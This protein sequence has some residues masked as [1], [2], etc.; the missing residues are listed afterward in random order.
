[1]VSYKLIMNKSL[2]N[3]P[4]RAVRN[5]FST[6]RH[7]PKAS[8]PFKL[9]MECSSICNLRC[10]MCPLSVGLKRKQGVLKFENFKYVF[11][12]VNPAYLNLTG[13]GE[14]FMNPDLFKIVKYAKQRNTMVKLDSNGTLLNKENIDKILDSKIDILST[15]IDGTDKKS[16]EKIRVG[17]NFDLI[18]KNIKALT[19]ERNRRK[20]KTEVHM[21]FILQEDN[22]KNLPNFIRLA[23]ELGVDYLAG[24]FVVTLGKNDNKKNKIFK[25]KKEDIDKAIKETEELIKKTKVEVSIIPLLEYLRND[26]DKEFYNKDTPCFMPWYSTFITWDGWVNPCDF[27]CDNEEV[28]GNVFKEPFKKVWNNKKYQNFRMQLLKQ[29]DKIAI[30]KGCGVNETYIENEFSKIKKI[31]FVKSLQ[32][33]PR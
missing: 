16:Y 27:S 17:S 23:E 26:K 15:S 13:I 10:K 14:P 31:P 20:S 9:K 30:C 28:F 12:Q 32:Y 1:M 3:K 25:Y 33:K 24:S 18:K 5:G 7:A 11:D 21:F 29:R 8:L 2:R 6:F 4:L 22:I 19:A